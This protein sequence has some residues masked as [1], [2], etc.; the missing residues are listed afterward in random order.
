MRKNEISLISNNT[1]WCTYN[2]YNAR[3]LFGDCSSNRNKW[4]NEII[5][6]HQ[7][8]R[9]RKCVE[10]RYDNGRHKQRNNYKEVFLAFVQCVFFFLLSKKCTSKT[11]RRNLYQISVFFRNKFSQF[12]KNRWVFCCKILWSWQQ[13]NSFFFRFASRSRGNLWIYSW[14]W[15]THSDYECFGHEDEHANSFI[16]N[17]IS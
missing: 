11:V 13:R 8:L 10:G 3:S 7:N 9:V 6:L 12:H 14:S 17:P 4:Q 5:K 1:K 15:L 2:L 16:V